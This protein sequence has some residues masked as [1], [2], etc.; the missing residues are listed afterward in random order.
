MTS[1]LTSITSRKKSP[2]QLCTSAI[3]SLNSLLDINSNIEDK[4]VAED[5][6]CKRL[7]QI[8]QILYGDD[9]HPQVDEDKAREIAKYLISHK[10]L[11]ML[12]ENISNIPFEVRK[13]TA[14]IFNNLLNKVIKKLSIYNNFL[15]KS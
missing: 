1:F 13:N 12:I 5:S 15:F 7:T 14:L 9:E 8:K 10:L 2:E 11:A 4:N 3:T 6:L